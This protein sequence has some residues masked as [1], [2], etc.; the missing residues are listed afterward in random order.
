[1]FA[2]PS[3]SGSCCVIGESS[4]VGGNWHDQTGEK[5]NMILQTHVYSIIQNAVIFENLEIF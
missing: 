2:P 3:Y 5:K 1:M 4:Q